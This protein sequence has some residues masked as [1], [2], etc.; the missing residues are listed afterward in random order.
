MGLNAQL[1][2]GMACNYTVTGGGSST[3]LTNLLAY[4]KL[5]EATGDADDAVGSANLVNTGATQG[6]TGHLGNAAS[7]N[8]TSN[9]LGQIDATFE[10][11]TMSVAVWVNTTQTGET[12]GIVDNYNW[13]GD[14][15]SVEIGGEW[16]NN[17]APVFHL[18][19][20]ANELILFDDTS[21]SLINNGSWH[22]IIA[23]FDGSTANLYLD[24]V[25]QAS[26]A[27]AH[28][29]TYDASGNIFKLGCRG[30]SPGELWYAGSID[31]PAIWTK[32]LSSTER[33]NLWN[34]GTGIT[35]PFTGY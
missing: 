17:G 9:Y 30:A 2:P 14:G 33:T 21:P 28:T 31:E 10:I 32:V 26:A 8:G 18:N 29:I 11:Q 15:W 4:Y 3:L 25:L 13:T 7:F 34:S 6:A 24:D 20:G 19:D 1:Y 5:D 16:N 27:W 23:T 35:Y 12:S 22:L